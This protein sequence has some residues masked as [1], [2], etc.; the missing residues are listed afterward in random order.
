VIGAFVLG[1]VSSAGEDVELPAPV[2][3]AHS[4]V[5]FSSS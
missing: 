1:R 5:P 4:Q 3:F 2:A